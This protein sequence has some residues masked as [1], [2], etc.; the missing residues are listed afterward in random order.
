MLNALKGRIGDLSEDFNREIVSIIKGHRNN[1]K[2][3]VI[4]EKCK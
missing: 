2:E 1:E 3:P 4:N